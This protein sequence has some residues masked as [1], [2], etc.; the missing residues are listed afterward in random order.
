MTQP[1]YNQNGPNQ[2]GLSKWGKALVIVGVVIFGLGVL[3]LAAGFV[4]TATVGAEGVNV[5]GPHGQADCMLSQVRLSIHREEVVGVPAPPVGFA[6]YGIGP[7]SG[8][9]DSWH[10]T[11]TG[12]GF[13]PATS[14]TW[15]GQQVDI[16][17]F[18]GNKQCVPDSSTTTSTTTTLAPPGPSTAPVP[19]PVV[20]EPQ[21]PPA[22]AVVA[23][24]ATLGI[25]G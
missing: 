6:P 10:V 15:A 1:S 20:P 21:A 2:T 18:D 4:A 12:P 3:V 7:V 9:N 8:D 5:H 13:A 23:N 11:L 22:A 19:A 25:T 16:P 14:G 24:P 17:A